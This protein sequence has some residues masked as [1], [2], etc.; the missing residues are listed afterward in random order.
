M[1]T[2]IRGSHC[3]AIALTRGKSKELRRTGVEI[4]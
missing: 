1:G 2:D 3:P 4:G